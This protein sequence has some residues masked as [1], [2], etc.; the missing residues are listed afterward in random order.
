[1]RQEIAILGW[2]SL[3][4][5]G[6]DLPING[7][8]ENDGPTLPL[9][10][11]RVSADGRLTLVIDAKFGKQLPSLYALSSRS[12][13]ADAVCDLCHREGTS[14]DKIGRAPKNDNLSKFEQAIDGWRRRKQFDHVIWTN[15]EPNFRKKC[16][17]DFS[18]AR[19]S[20]YLRD[21][22]RACQEHAREYLRRAPQQIQ[23]PLREHLKEWV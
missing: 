23:T 22:P 5:D 18:I 19:A 1:M 13:V 2:G 12:N 21:L 3:I 7:S 8:W 6:R 15:L 17:E 4:W 9:E 16:G 11:S 20:A 14:Q 10:F